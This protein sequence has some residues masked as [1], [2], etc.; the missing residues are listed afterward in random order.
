ME[1]LDWQQAVLPRHIVGE[2]EP[3]VLPLLREEYVGRV[4]LE[5]VNKG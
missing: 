4:R 3:V 1:P 5:K 2:D